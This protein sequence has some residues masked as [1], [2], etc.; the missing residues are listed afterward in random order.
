ESRVGSTSWNLCLRFRIVQNEIRG[1][2]GEFHFLNCKNGNSP[3]C[4]RISRRSSE[5]VLEL[6]HDALNFTFG[7]AASIS[8]PG[9][10]QIHEVVALAV[11]SVEIVRAQLGPLMVEFIAKLLPFGSEN[12]WLHLRCLYYLHVAA[13]RMPAAPRAYFWLIRFFGTTLS[14]AST[15]GLTAEFMATLPFRMSFASADSP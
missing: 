6:A 7:A 12:V 14:S 9:F 11:D 1:Q 2:T 8:V 13:R 10:E 5:L 3:V 15:N 4:P